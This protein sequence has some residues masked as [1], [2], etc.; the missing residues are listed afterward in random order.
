LKPALFRYSRARSGPATGARLAG[1]GGGARLA[2]LGGKARLAGLGGKARLAG[3]GG[4]TILAGGSSLV[5]MMNFRLSRP[6]A[7]AGSAGRLPL[8]PARVPE[9]ATNGGGR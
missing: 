5:L 3:L 2:G 4:D 7:R 9:L 8:T 1:L 6:G